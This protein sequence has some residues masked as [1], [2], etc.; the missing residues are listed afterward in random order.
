MTQT[1]VFSPAR[2]QIVRQLTDSINLVEDFPLFVRDSQF[3]R[4]LDGSSQL[5]C[6]DLQ[7]CQL[8]LSYEVAQ[9]VGEL[10]R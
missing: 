4:C 1:V 3:L 6:P 5:A 7:I 2:P 10:G 8:V 9:G